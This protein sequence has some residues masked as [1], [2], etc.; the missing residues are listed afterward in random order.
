MSHLTRRSWALQ[1]RYMTVPLNLTCY[2]SCR[3]LTSSV[4]ASAQG[5]SAAGGLLRLFM[6]LA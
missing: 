6:W 5:G 4:L 2:G 3:N 1:M